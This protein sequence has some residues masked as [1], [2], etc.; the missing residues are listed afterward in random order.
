MASDKSIGKIIFK[1]LI[2]NISPLHIGSGASDNSDLDVIVDESGCPFIPAT[3][4]VGVL[5]HELK[6]TKNNEEENTTELKKFWGYTEK[7]DGHQSL[8]RCS[9]LVLNDNTNYTIVVRDG[10]KMDNRTGLVQ[11]MGK[12]DYQIV[13]PNSQFKLNMEFSY[14]D[15][16]EKQFMK[17]MV[18]TIYNELT[19]AGKI[20]VGAKTNNG[21]GAMQLIDSEMQIYHFDFSNKKH[22]YHWLTDNSH[23]EN[24]VPLNQFKRDFKDSFEIH[25]RIFKIEATFKLKNS[26]IIGS[27]SENPLF[28]DKTHITS[29]GKNVLPGASLKGALRARAERI[30]NTLGKSDEIIKNL[31]GNVEERKKGNG[32]TDKR[33][34]RLQVKEIILPEFIL[35]MQRRIK[36]DRFTG[37]TIEAALFDSTPLFTDFSE[38]VNHVTITIKN[39]KD[40]EA[41]LMLFVL[42]DLWAGDLAIGGEKNIGRGVFEGGEAEIHWNNARPVAITKTDISGLLKLEHFI[43]AFNKET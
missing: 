7:K 38:K 8:F 6:L 19:E 16:I 17:R 21:L 32:K 5:N 11:D 40:S 12:Y 30:V 42:K 15:N 3:S 27:Y 33:K 2:E 39:F 35:E 24:I 22:V 43:E 34:G 23:P 26:L 14:R 4:F 9:D 29:N 28:S 20:K 25:D 18:R 37:G 13:E 10:I 31:F 41:G 1:G 36:I